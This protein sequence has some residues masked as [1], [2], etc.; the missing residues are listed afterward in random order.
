LPIAC[1]AVAAAALVGCGADRAADHPPSSTE[2]VTVSVVS[3]VRRELPRTIRVT[4]TL[5]G[6]EE[7][8]IAAKVS[9]RIIEILKDMGDAALPGEALLRVDPTD[10]ELA[11]TER[12]R[13]FVESLA[14]LGLSELPAEGIDVNA[15]P[16]VER[17]RLQA[18]NAK[19]KY[20]RARVLAERDPPLISEQ[21]FADLKTAW[22]VAQSNL[23]VERLTAEATLA[24]ARTIDAQV[25]MAEQRVNDAVH[26]APN[27]NATNVELRYE[28]A[29]R[30]VT[31]GDFVPVGAP[32]MRLVDADPLKLRAPVLERRLGAVKTG[33]RVIVR[34]EAFDR[35]FEG[36]V[37]RV[38][39]AVDTATRSFPV[40][41][42]VPNRER[43]LKPGSF[44]T[45][46]IEIGRES[47]L[48]LP[49]SAVITFAGVH[50]VVLAQNGK[51]KE[52]RV[53]LGERVDDM[54][55]IRGGIAET[56]QVVLRP[57]GSLVTGTPVR[58]APSDSQAANSP[59]LDV[60]SD[61][62]STP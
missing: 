12:E 52:Q 35:A 44:A 1:G 5:H 56:D 57:P 28:V 53:E 62:G 19:A 45:A 31:V 9:G 16:S 40:E 33:Q 21:D 46:E 8:T 48:M 60:S 36:D 54:V 39:P 37:A 47:A 10:Y 3:P 23:K 55:E 14:E 43:L 34:V 22:D 2:A 61:R 15:L 24:E 13:A 38:S 42:I 59:T 4:G 6:E 29:A 18:E 32:L 20:E 7:T 51:A 11:R 49:A 41:I 25:K 17:A 30:L 58:V 27:S 50:K 26:R